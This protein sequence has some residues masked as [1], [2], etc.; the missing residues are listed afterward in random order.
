MGAKQERLFNVQS[1]FSDRK[2]YAHKKMH[3]PSEKSHAIHH[4]LE[5]LIVL[6]ENFVLVSAGFISNVHQA[7]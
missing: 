3:L 5:I 6:D 2:I 4:C 1:I 7:V